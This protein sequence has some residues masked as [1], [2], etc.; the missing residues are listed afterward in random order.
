[1]LL[2]WTCFSICFFNA[3]IPK[4]VRNDRKT[5]QKTR[6]L[7]PVSASRCV[8]LLNLFQHLFF[9]MRGFRTK[10]GMTDKNN[11]VIARALARGNLFLFF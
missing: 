10:F 3:G 5:K 7:A 2:F 8:V 11:T 1:M 4:R 6:G 9:L